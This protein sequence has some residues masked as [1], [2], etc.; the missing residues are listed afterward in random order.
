MLKTSWLLADLLKLTYYRN[1]FFAAWN[2]EFV[3]FLS[4]WFYF[5]LILQCFSIDFL[6]F[7]SSPPGVFLAKAVLK[8][9]NTHTT[10]W[11]Q[12]SC[13]TTLLQS[14]LT[15]CQKGK[16]AECIILRQSSSVIILIYIIYIISL[17]VSCFC[18]LF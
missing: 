14:R 1:L 8:I 13:F 9:C 12:L 15:Q 6:V 4:N 11:F 16:G 3:T 18:L 7:R 17:W 2:N 5:I 10:W